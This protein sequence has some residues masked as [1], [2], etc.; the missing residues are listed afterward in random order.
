MVPPTVPLPQVPA[1]ALPMQKAPKQPSTVKFPEA[2]PPMFDDPT[3]FIE[4]W[5]DIAL[6]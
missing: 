4:L 2:M 3:M 6:L 1:E 5:A